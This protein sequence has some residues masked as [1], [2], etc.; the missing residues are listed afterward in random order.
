MVALDVLEMETLDE[1][2]KEMPP[3]EAKKP[4]K[5]KFLRDIASKVVDLI[6]HDWEGLEEVLSGKTNVSDEKMDY[7]WCHCKTGTH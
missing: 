3:N 4:T 6:W 5:R 7:P 2:P 1:L